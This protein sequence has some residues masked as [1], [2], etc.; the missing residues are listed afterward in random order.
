MEVIRVAA[1]FATN[2]CELPQGCSSPRETT[3][4]SR[5]PSS[6]GSHSRVQS[7][8][9]NKNLE[10]EACKATLGGLRSLHSLGRFERRGSLLWD[11]PVGYGSLAQEFGIADS[12]VSELE[13]AEDSFRTRGLVPQ[14]ESTCSIGSSSRVRVGN[15]SRALRRSNSFDGFLKGRRQ[16]RVAPICGVENGVASEVI[17]E[18]PSTNISSHS[19]GT[20]ILQ[21]PSY[22]ESLSLNRTEQGSRNSKGTHTLTPLKESVSGLEELTEVSPFR[23]GHLVEC[24]EVEGGRRL[25][26]E[27]QI[28]GAKNS[29]LAILA[30][31]ICSEGQVHLEMIPE[32][33]DIRRMFQVLQ[34]VG[35]KVQRTSSGFMIDARDLTS[36]EPCPETVRKLRASFFVIGSL[37]GRK[38]EAVVPLP[39]GCDIGARPIDL[40]VRGLEALG[41]KVDIRQG[42]VH[43]RARNGKN[44]TGGS[45]FLDYPSVGATETL[46]MAAALADGHTT[47]SNVAQEPEV[48]DLANFL[49]SCGA[50]IRGAGT[51]TL[52]ITGTRKL[53]G[54]E[55]QIIPDRIE[56]GTFLM[57]AAITRSGIS[58]CPVI[59]K[60]LS[61]VIDKLRMIGCRIQQNGW[62]SLQINCTEHL[63][64]CDVKTL[65]YPGFPT[66]LQPQLM[67]LL[68]T[69][70]GHSVLEETVFEGRMRH[71][72]ELQKLGAQMKVS[73]NVAIIHGKDAGSTLFGAPVSATDLR[74]GAA[75]VLAGMSAEGTTYI[76]GVSHIDRGYERLDKKLQLLGA[77]IQRVPC[78]PTDLTL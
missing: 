67:S 22:I 20:V 45:F 37:L 35:V 70:S 77:S 63:R 65:P 47:L 25:S 48:V 12:R 66:D 14:G 21:S 50:R 1:N 19:P 38:G 64:S 4:C 15:S 72:E 24:F 57:A 28:S 16:H 32:L 75:L 2:S 18:A 44:L 17:L 58:M 6:F 52:S 69:C 27:V 8:K 71:A 10:R 36:V 34:S 31:V 74:A 30:G 41:A 59:P 49:I 55:Y 5:K 43:A 11:N 51:S 33:H 40:H 29:A 26:G 46:M 13:T 23:P 78:L 54:T 9:Y 7:R 61:S 53:H 39:G 56:A 76:Q 73:Q 42:K 60:H 68:T 62:N 3:S